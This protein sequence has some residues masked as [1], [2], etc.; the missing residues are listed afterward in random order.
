MVRGD[1]HPDHEAVGRAAR[2][3]ARRTDAILLEYP[4]WMWH[5]A[6]TDDF[7]VSWSRAQRAVETAR[8]STQTGCHCMLSQ[9][10]EATLPAPR[11]RHAFEPGCSIGTLTEGLAARRDA[12]TATDVAATALDHAD[13]RLRGAGCRE[14]V[15]L[16]L[17][18]LDEPWPKGDFDLVALSEVGYYL[19]AGTLRSVLDREHKRLHGATLVPRIDVTVSRT[20]R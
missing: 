13:R 8:Y 4:I 15:N 7:A 12:I 6:F 17:H 1:G 19:Q 16:M 5:W 14:Q 2:S 10:V 3:A 20:I 9:P 18:P 11:Y